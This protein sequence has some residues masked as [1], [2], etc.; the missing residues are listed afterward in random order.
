MYKVGDLVRIKKR[1]GNWYDYPLSYIDG[2]LD[3]QEVIAKVIKVEHDDGAEI[4]RNLKY[5]DGDDY[6]YYLDVT[7]SKYLWSSPMLEPYVTNPHFVDLNN[8]LR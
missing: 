3:Y 5:Y 8:I 7:N 1:E 4:H 2:M 6:I